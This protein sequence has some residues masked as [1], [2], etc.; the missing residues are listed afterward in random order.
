MTHL[1]EHV[2]IHASADEVY[3]RLAAL[4]EHRRWLPSAFRG[5]VATRDSLS[6]DLRLPLRRDRARLAVTGDEAPALLVLERDG[7]EGGAGSIH[8]LTWALH[9]E[10]PR[11]VHLTL[12]VA[13]HPAGGALGSL[14]EVALHR[15]LRQQAFREALWRLKLLIE[16]GG[17]GRDGRDG[18]G[19]RGTGAA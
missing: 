15:R 19:G 14:L 7:V 5:V 13:Y 6:F 10:A 9:V 8:S 1:R 11:E 17:E 4:E 2:H 16:R 18:S 12:E 3:G